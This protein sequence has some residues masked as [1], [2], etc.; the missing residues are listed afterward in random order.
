MRDNT[1]LS[2]DGVSLTFGGVKALDDVSIDI[3]K[4]EVLCIIGPN[5][6]GK[7]T[8]FNCI[9]GFLRPSSG[10]IM[11]RGGIELTG[12]K[13]HQIAH[14]GIYRSFQNLAT[15]TQLSTLE[16]VLIGGLKRHDF[17]YGLT[18]M[19]FNTRRFRYRESALR[20]EA[21]SI[22]EFIGIVGKKDKK[23]AELSYGERK[24][25]ELARGLITKPGLLL[26]DEPAAGLNPTEKAELAAAIRKI[27]RENIDVV[28]IEHDMKF[29]S[30]IS[31][32]IVVLDYG[33][34]L[35]EGTPEDI[36][37]NKTVIEAYLGT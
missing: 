36:K 14:Y 35:A 3:K 28:L 27:C 19:L 18:D 37:K 33:K 23:A 30:D 15:F 9:T 11:Y 13:P 29:V 20:D 22:L 32:W 6:A 31:H 24:L 8:L 10:S 1:V 2:I 26:L 7:T 5:G 12:R 21:V 16:N 4:G 34:K 17:S 25:L